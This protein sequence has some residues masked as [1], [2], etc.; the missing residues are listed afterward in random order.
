MLEILKPAGR[1]LNRVFAPSLIRIHLLVSQIGAAIGVERGKIQKL[2]IPNSKLQGS[3]K[4][5]IPNPNKIPNSKSQI[6]KQAAPAAF[7]SLEVVIFLELG[8]WDLQ[9]LWSLAFGAWSLASPLPTGETRGILLRLPPGAQIGPT[10][11][12]GFGDRPKMARSRLE[13]LKPEDSGVN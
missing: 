10:P 7:L 12:V 2:Q 5:Q 8:F 13:K 9:L 6:S 3:S 11:I 1:L 4:H